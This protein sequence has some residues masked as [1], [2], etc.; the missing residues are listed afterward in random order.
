MKSMLKFIAAAVIGAAT[1]TACGGHYK[2][3]ETVVVAQPDYKVTDIVAG[4]GQVAKL[5]VT[6]IVYDPADAALPVADRTILISYLTDTQLVAIRYTGYLYDS[7]KADGKGEILETSVTGE[8]IYPVQPFTLGAGQPIAGTTALIGFDKAIVG[9]A[10]GGKRTVVLPASL[11]YGA[12]TLAARDATNG[13]GKKFPALPANAPLVYDIELVAITEL[14]NIIPA[15]PPTV[16]TDLV[17]PTVGT[18]AEAVVG[19]YAQVRYTLYYYDGTRASRIGTQ[20]ETNVSTDTT[21]KA[22]SFLVTDVEKDMT[23]IVGFNNAVK[24]MK[25]GGKRTVIIPGK[26]AYGKTGT[27]TI[28]PNTS[29]IFDITLESVADTKQ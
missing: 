9:M 20:I 13:S 14:P 17:T 23:T 10:V 12:S 4:T 8:S 6:N 16:V 19:K 7:A 28:A 2:K 11:A 21:V 5:G 25:V 27:S 3:P 26:L 15:T 24:G 1:L 22:L 29:L 18:G